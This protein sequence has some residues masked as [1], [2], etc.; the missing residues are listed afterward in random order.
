[1]FY[2]CLCADFYD[3]TGNTGKRRILREGTYKKTSARTLHML[4]SQCPLFHHDLRSLALDIPFVVLHLSMLVCI[5]RMRRSDTT[6]RT[7]FFTIYALVSFTDIISTLEVPQLRAEDR[8][9]G[10]GPKCKKRN[11]LC[12]T[13][14]SG[15]SAYGPMH[16]PSPAH[17]H[18]HSS[19]HPCSFCSAHHLEISP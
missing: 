6:L 3:A 15:S 17:G 11:M 19:A 2:I 18:A 13:Y 5:L 12:R 9:S 7:G 14:P 10:P 16:L 1:M 8:T 4:T